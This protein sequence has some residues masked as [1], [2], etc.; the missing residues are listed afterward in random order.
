MGIRLL[1]SL[2]TS[3]SL[4]L[5]L[6]IDSTI[7]NYISW[8][9]IRLLDYLSILAKKSSVPIPLEGWYLQI[10]E[11]ILWNMKLNVWVLRIIFYLLIEIYKLINDSCSLIF[12][13]LRCLQI[14]FKFFFFLLLLVIGFGLLDCCW[15]IKLLN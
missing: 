1:V 4:H 9:S 5:S 8:L 6:S 3:T 11:S 13:K 15:L 2:N 10:L 14:N 12:C 7:L